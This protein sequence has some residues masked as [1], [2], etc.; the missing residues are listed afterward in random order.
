MSA[1]EQAGPLPAV[2]STRGGLATLGPDGLQLMSALQRMVMRLAQACGAQQARFPPLL[3]VEDLDALDYFRNF[4][5]LGLAAAPLADS[6]LPALAASREARHALCAHELGEARHLLPSA[7]CYGVYAHLRG[8]TLTQPLYVTTT[9]TCFRNETAYEDLQRL[10][11]F[12]MQEIVCLG[13]LNEAQAHL[14]RSLAAIVA[15][16][17]SLGIELRVELAT[18]PFF[19][20]QSP[21]ARFQER[22]PTKREL[23]YEGLAVSSVNFHR[24]FFGER[25]SIRDTAGA[26]VFTSCVAFGLERWMHMLLQRYGGDAAAATAAVDTLLTA[27]TRSAV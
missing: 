5:H 10:W 7:A 25:F 22:A 18:D 14:E 12:T 21:V 1:A 27:D 17:A 3:R 8:A 11:A 15:A 24:N 9:A 20:R 16:V 4:P 13:P 23:L 26:P 2:A 6:Q 19:D